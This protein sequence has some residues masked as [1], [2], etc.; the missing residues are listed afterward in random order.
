MPV[1]NGALLEGL[2][3]AVLAA[4]DTAGVGIAVSEATATGVVNLFLS[5]CAVQILGHSREVLATRSALDNIAE[6]ERPALLERL[7]AS[8]Q[9]GADEPPRALETVVA[10]ADG[11][12][13]PIA[14]AVSSAILDGRAV[15]VAFFVD[16]R[17]RARAMEALAASE[18]RFRSLIEAANDTVAITRRGVITYANTAASRA[19]GCESPDELVGKTWDTLLAPEDFVFMSERIRAMIGDG[20]EFPPHEYRVTRRDG[21]EAVIEIASRVILDAGEPTVIGFGRDVTE[22][23]RLQ[24]QLAHGDRLAALG[25]LAAEIAHEINNPLAYVSLSARALS[26][27]LAEAKLAPQTLATA[28]ELLGNVLTGADR[29]AAIVRD[30]RAFTR[31]DEAAQP[32]AVQLCTVVEASLRIAG[33]ELRR[34][35]RVVA[36][37]ADDLFVFGTARAVEQVVVNLLVNAAHA[38]PENQPD[39]EI[40]VRAAVARGGWITLDVADQGVGIAGTDLPRIFDPFFTTKPTGVG[41]GLGLSVCHS[42]VAQMGGKIEVVT[43]ASTGTTVRVT[44]LAATPSQAKRVRAKSE[45]PPEG[46][47]LRIL[48]V[49]D[50]PLIG[51]TVVGLLSQHH[52]PSFAFGGAAGLEQALGED[53]DVVLCDLAMA[54]VSGMELFTRLK[55]ARPLLAARTVFMTG[56]ATIPRVAEFLAAV[57]NLR[58]EKPFR[59]AALLAVLAE[60]S[61]RGENGAG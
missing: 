35:A 44:L 37:V 42:L 60:A 27:L 15:T 25:T 58:I 9:K 48:V 59:A 5:D 21:T 7:A 19:L 24:A 1:G 46:E 55:Q 54:G 14:V 18:A 38:T 40:S 57:D 30:L 17:A 45:P 31:S 41:T 56:G 36:D 26:D 12:R 23:K 53:F 6:E 2:S 16:L 47:G 32:E 13:V 43:T 33:H 52:H 8:R 10:Q 20:T 51:E 34:R 3:T 50:E 49:D 29:V 28:K 22:R 39:A 11:T 4:A 61:R